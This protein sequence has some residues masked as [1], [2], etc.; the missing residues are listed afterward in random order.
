VSADF[1]VGGISKTSAGLKQGTSIHLLK[2]SKR[3]E[4]KVMAKEKPT[5]VKVDEDKGL[6]IITVPILKPLKPSKTGK[7]LTVAT[8]H[9]NRPTEAQVQGK[10][11]IV[12]VNAY[13]RND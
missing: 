5:T 1:E 4:T 10:P 3:K 12:G 13:I 2:P 9:G 7:S 6:L 8:T 11:L